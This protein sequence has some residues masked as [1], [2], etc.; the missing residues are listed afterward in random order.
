M[1]YHLTLQQEQEVRAEIDAGR[2]IEA[3][4]R[5][6]EFTGAGLK[7]AKDAV[8]AMRASPGYTASTGAPATQGVF[9]SE[10]GTPRLDPSTRDEIK[11]LALSGNKIQAIKQYREATHASLVDAKRAVEAMIEGRATPAESRLEQ[12]ATN[13]SGGGCLGMI[14]V[15]V[16][17]ALLAFL[18]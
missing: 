12:Q 2:L 16:S 15:S 5:F 8:D 3:I 13:Q 11:R 4:K 6:R 9:T 10:L 17:M 14:V 7:E 1:T 18:V